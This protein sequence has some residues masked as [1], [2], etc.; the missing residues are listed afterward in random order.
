MRRFLLLILTFAIA[1]GSVS[2]QQRDRLADLGVQCYLHGAVA[3]DGSLWLGTACGY[4]YRADNIHSPWRTMVK[5]PENSWRHITFEGVAPFN[6]NVAVAVGY[7]LDNS[8]LR[9]SGTLWNDTVPAGGSRKWE[10][11]HPTWRGEGGRVWAGS[12]DGLLTFSADSGRSFIALRDSA[13][14]Q[15]LGIDDIYMLTADSGWIAGHGNRIYT[16]SDN[17]STY[18]RWQTPLDQKLYV[19]TDPHDQYW[20]NRI[21]PWKGHLFVSQAFMSFVSPFGDTLHWRH[22]AH[23]IRQFEVD[24]AADVLWALDDSGHVVRY[25]DVDRYRRYP[26]VAHDII[27][28][29]GGRSFWLTSFGV[30]ALSADGHMDTCAFLTAERPIEEPG[31]TLSQ[32]NRLWGTDGVSVYLLDDQGWYRV[33]R[34]GGV[35]SLTPDPD[36]EDRVLFVGS[37]NGV[38]SV[39]TVGHVAPYTYRHPLEA[40]VKEGVGGLE[41]EIYESGCYHYDAHTIRYSRRGERLEEIYNN[42]DSNHFITRHQPVAKV[43][44]ALMALGERYSDFPSPQDFGL[45][46][47]TIDLHEAFASTGWSTSGVGYHITIV[48]QS[49]DTLWATGSSS[50]WYDLSG[51]IRFPWLLP[52]KVSWRGAAF[53]T[54]QPVLWQALKPMMPDGMKLKSNLD[55]S[56]LHPIYKMQSGDLLF[57]SAGSTDMGDAIQK[58][59]GKYTH[60]AILEVE[61][62]DKYKGGK[63]VWVIEATP[64]EGVVRTPWAKWND[65]FQAAIYR[66]TVPFDTAAVIERAKS[67]VGKEYDYAFLPDNDKYYCSELVYECYLDSVGNHLFEAKPMNWRDKKGKL[68]KYWKKHFKKLGI[69]VPEGVPGTNPTD[70]SRSPLLKKQQ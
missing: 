68:P 66:L 19:V 8:V 34:P 13:F 1:S 29:C 50:Q 67:L 3:P 45:E 48:N 40:F 15:K 18:R 28:I 69:P 52:M 32:G 35:R 6:R 5:P 2:G 42:I 23:P 22:T 38:F 65:R 64:E 55:N 58:S 9:V 37:D 44:Q 30:V 24:T 53:V 25:E 51:G 31:L 11:F 49:G 17:W 47:S 39:D 12:Q 62:S 61:K 41:I 60:V 56:T 63:A 57:V 33:C 27:G 36:R 20:V 70:L 46:D 43:E 59:T 14:E 21:R 7:H 10:W 4:L 26:L 16:S 54:Y